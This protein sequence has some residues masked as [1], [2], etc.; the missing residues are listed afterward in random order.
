MEGKVFEKP[1]NTPALKI[2][3]NLWIDKL[4]SILSNKVLS[5]F[6]LM[7]N[8]FAQPTEEENSSTYLGDHTRRKGLI[9]PGD[10]KF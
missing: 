6:L 2:N 8:G 1:L 5:R 10:H 9:P 7:K 3:K 4:V